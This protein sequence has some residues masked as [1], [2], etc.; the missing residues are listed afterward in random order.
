MQSLLTDVIKYFK[1]NPACALLLLGLLVMF[2]PTF[3]DLFST[4][5]W[6]DDEHGH[7]PMIFA[8]SLWLLSK[9]WG[10]SHLNLHQQK[11]AFIAA[12]LTL[13]VGIVFYVIG[14]ALEI[15]Y[16]EVAAFPVV[17]TAIVLFLG[18]W[19][20]ANTLKF[21][22]F[23]MIFMI[24]LPGFI[25]DPVSQLL[26]HAVSTVT[27]D[28]LYAAGYPIS[29]SGVILQIAQYQLLVA[30]ACSGMRTLFM[31]EALGIL[32][33]NLVRYDS[34]FRNIMLAIL[35]VPISF[36]ANVIR[37]I[38]LSLI[39][40]YFGDAA[41]QGFL[42]GFAGMV[43]FIAALLLMLAVDRLLRF[44]VSAWRGRKQIYA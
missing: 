3:Y 10:E 4:G 25:V 14:R 32:Y 29:R 22:L 43:L 9:R 18:G 15:I 16:L 31:L 40:Y 28:L 13:I 39:T 17:C 38:V 21:P 36:T 30:D 6:T 41:G 24:P 7:G 27:A 44:L 34:W 20:L 2:V 35:I 42:H 8:I 37:V 26:K 11:P 5:I 33:M 23:F 12:W 1:Q 19:R